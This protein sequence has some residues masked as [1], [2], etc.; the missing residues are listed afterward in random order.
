MNHLTKPRDSAARGEDGKRQG[1][2]DL[3]GVACPSFVARAL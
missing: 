3:L 1:A 2:L